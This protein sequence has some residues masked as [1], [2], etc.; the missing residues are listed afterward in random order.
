MP[1]PSAQT[2]TERLEAIHGLLSDKLPRLARIAVALYD[3]NTDMLHTL[4]HS[5]RGE[6]PLSHYGIALSEVPSLREL[7]RQGGP[8]IA[9]DLEAAYFHGSEHSRRIIGQGYRSSY[10]AVLSHRDAVLGFVFFN[11][12]EAG[13]FDERA[14]PIV[15]CAARLVALTIGEDLDATRILMGA[16]VALGKVAR[17]RDPETGEHLERM[18]RFSREI[19]LRLAE[20]WGLTDEFVENVFLYAPL[21]DIGKLAMPDAILFKPEGLDPG[22][23]EIMRQHPARGCEIVQIMLDNAAA[24]FPHIELL[25]HIIRHH[26]ECFDGSGYPDGLTG[27][28]I[29]VEA[30]I[31]AVADSFDALTSLRP[32]KDRW[33]NA[34]ALAWMQAHAGSRFDP[35]CIVALERSLPAIARIQDAIRDPDAVPPG[36]TADA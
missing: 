7:L 1:P 33:D 14:L 34:R 12:Y 9:N 31:V 17:V 35:E 29:P 13:Q 3:A 2:L 30:R 6:D 5:S 21:H 11:S 10:T 20:P 22:E 18:A 16:I 23:W 36:P 27:C 32:Y 19:A 4:A 26:H 28:D 8:R 15:E 24:P 25:R